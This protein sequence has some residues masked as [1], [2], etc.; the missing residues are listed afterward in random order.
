MSELDENR[1]T[2][3]L[4]NIE[5]CQVILTCTDKIDIKGNVKTFYVESGKVKNCEGD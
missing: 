5:G 3:F 2:S 1:R 4:E